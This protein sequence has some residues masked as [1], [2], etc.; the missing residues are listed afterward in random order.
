M[1]LLGQDWF[2]TAAARMDWAAARQKAL[3]ENVANADTPH[4]I[5]RD[6][7]SFE[8]HLARAE[9]RGEVA[10]EEANNSWG[11]SFNGNMVTVEEQMMFSN[12]AAGS[13]K[14][15]TSLYKKGH[16]LLAIAASA[17]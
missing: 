17:R 7:V 4:Y 5:G 12:E 13:Y 10:T 1:D 8:D 9:R 2:K 6:V 3:A 16:S 14:L 15:A 11:G